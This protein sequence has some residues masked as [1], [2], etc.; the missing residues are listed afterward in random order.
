M[1]FRLSALALMLS[2]GTAFATCSRTDATF[3]SCPVEGSGKW[4]EVCAED[5][6]AVY[7]YG[8]LGRPELE[9]TE[10]YGA[11]DYEPWPGVGRSIWETVTFYNG[12]YSYSV[13]ISVDRMDENVAPEGGVAVRKGEE[14]VASLTCAEGRADIGWTERLTEGKN[15]AGLT[16]DPSNGWSR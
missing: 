3:V 4:L 2:A 12:A 5:W 6:G 7:R 11:L 16:W 9:L 1:L 13:Y 10:P 14:V 15:R 8:L